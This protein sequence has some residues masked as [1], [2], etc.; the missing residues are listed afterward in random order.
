MHNRIEIAAAMATMAREM[1]IRH[2]FDD[3]LKDRGAGVLRYV[4]AIGT[5]R[6]LAWHDDDAPPVSNCCETTSSR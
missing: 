5:E 4:L 2:V 6:Y 1:S 3:T